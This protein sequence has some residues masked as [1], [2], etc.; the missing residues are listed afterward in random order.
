M[1]RTLVQTELIADNSV[2]SAKIAQ[3]SILTKHID[4]NQI[5]TDQIAANTIATANVADNAIDGTK[6]A[7]NS[8]L[9]RH[10]DDN[11]I[12]ID[13]LNVSDGSSG[14]ALTTDGSGT[15]SFASA[16]ETNRLPLAGGTLTGNLTMGGM[17]LKPSGDGGSI[18]FNRNPDN[19]NHVGD[20]SLRR[21]QING[22]DS[23]GGDFLQIQSY[24]SSGTHQ[25][26]INI[27]DGK[28]GIG[29]SS[30]SEPLHVVGDRIMLVGESSGAAALALRA[31]GNAEVQEIIV[32]QGFASGTDD[33]GFL[34]NRANA[35]FVF[36]TNNTERMRITSNGNLKFTGTTTNFESPGFTH[37]TNGY[38]YLRG[39]TSGLR[40]DD[41][42][43]INTI[44]ISDGSS[45]Y[46]KFETG[47][48]SE[49]MRIDSA[50]RLLINKTSSS[51]T[52][53]KLQVGAGG[54]TAGHGGIVFFEDTDA[55]VGSS[56]V[57]Q[58][59]WFTGDNDAT[60]GVFNRFRDGN[61][62]MGEITAANGTQVSYG[63]SSDERLKE[64]I[65][66][67]SSQLNTIKNIKVREFD[68]K[69]NSYHEVGMI[70]QELHSVIPSVVQEGLDDVSEKPWS[71]DYGK[72]TPYLIKAV[73]EQQTII[74]DLKTRI[75]TLEG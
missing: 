60:G 54:E 44:Q 5:T 17:I 23:T 29:T 36:G 55:S 52:Y 50:G 70:A 4:D 68:W 66:D 69:A 19:G 11:Q 75:E 72:L 22:P 40:L 67:A 20:S 31:D 73:Q 51:L 38:L 1:A 33:V 64:N 56:N 14:Q 49:R 32:G 61:S 39:G 13:Q 65:V 28:L 43:S 2:T 53:G 59:N 15:L 12:G 34:Y 10:I 41:D 7:S 25:G 27:I 8:I 42:S 62:V 24:N 26:N 6:I 18:G 9:T 47:D 46:I 63:V 58:V 30:P 37:H 71:V 48:G 21:F 16:G 35:D 3:N 57:I 74:E 45:G